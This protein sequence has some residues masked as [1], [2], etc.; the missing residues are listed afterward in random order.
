MPIRLSRRRLLCGVS[1]LAL[2]SLLPGPTHGEIAS[3]FGGN[4]NVTITAIDTSGGIV[5]SRVSGQ[6]QTP[7]FIHVSASAIKATGTPWPYE[8]LEFSW[9]FGDPNGAEIFVNPVTAAK[10]NANDSQT[11]PEAVYVYRKAGTYTVTLTIRG[12]NGETFTRAVAKSQFIVKA[13]KAIGGEY[14]FD[15]VNGSDSY[16]GLHPTHSA[17]PSGN[18]DGPKKN[19]TFLLPHSRM[20]I[21]LARGS[22]W[23]YSDG[24]NYIRTITN[25]TELRLD[26][27]GSGA[28]PIIECDSGKNPP[29]LVGNGAGGLSPGRP[30]SDIVFSNVHCIV[31][32]T[33]TSKLVGLVFCVNGTPDGTITNVYADNCKFES[34]LLTTVDTVNFS[35]G[36]YWNGS[37]RG[38]FW[39]CAIVNPIAGKPTRNRQGLAAQGWREWLFVVG[40][41]FE[42]AGSNPNHDHHIYPIVKDHS[43]YRWIKF[44]RGPGRSYCLNI[45]WN[46]SHEGICLAGTITG[47]TLNVPRAFGATRFEVG[48]TVYGKG[49]APG[50]TITSLGTGR[51]RNGT[52]NLSRPSTVSTPTLIKAIKSLEYSEFTLIDG[53]HFAGVQY[54][55]DSSDRNN[56]ASVVQWRNEICQNCAFDSL[57]GG[58]L[59]NGLNSYTARDNVVWGGPGT[60]PWF[61]PGLAAE[62][63]AVCEYKIYRNRIYRDSG[64]SP[65]IALNG[66]RATFLSRRPLQLTDNTFY[67]AR[68]AAKIV[69]LKSADH[70]HSIIDRNQY[71]APNATRGKIIYN[72][73]TALSFSSWQA[74]GAN[75]DPNS[76]VANPKWIDPAHGNFNT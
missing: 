73:H 13:F 9:N 11:G 45:D 63:C 14:Y 30:S 39:N 40:G 43:L 27:Y 22:H 6:M 1:A 24:G 42:G 56:D 21:H 46:N 15:Q 10:V 59:A 70:V 52:Y 69:A 67:D 17:T 20:A 75:F 51:G 41:F 47:T 23:K 25:T 37:S 57:T 38:G 53:C 8:D 5:A 2:V 61:Y 72:N 66:G 54:A 19:L 18:I 68:A 36:G 35:P 74:L 49:V 31:S 7:A 16:N 50:S 26:A 32:G 71:Y 76:T 64:R 29:I 48:Q 3:S 60:N 34:K 33:C 65:C 4:P 28:D 44:A 12:Q 55:H 58:I 62:I